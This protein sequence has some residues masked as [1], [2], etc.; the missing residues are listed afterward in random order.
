MKILFALFLHLSLNIVAQENIELKTMYTE[1]QNDRRSGAIDWDL[2]TKRDSTREKRVFEMLDSNLVKTSMDYYHAAMIFQHGG[3][4]IASSMAV[5]MMRHAIELDQTI[6]KW[7]LAA[8]IDRDLMRRGKP[9]IYG[10]QYRKMNNEPW[11][12]YDIDTTVISDTERR[13]YNVETLAEQ[14]AK[15]IS[16]NKTSLY[17]LY[18]SGITLDSIVMIITRESDLSN[19]EYN[20]SENGIN[21]FGYDLISMNLV[22]DALVIFRVNSEL[23]PKSSNTYDSLGECLLLLGKREEGIKAY[24]KALEL[25][26]DNTHAKGIVDKAE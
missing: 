17:D 15:V 11:K 16:M 8:A 18:V 23:Y 2:V 9:Q 24:K 14:R 4:T 19:S 22:E 26:P 5:K 20:L 21:E 25:N 12:L 3:D 1:D 10:T 6:N 13:E 7:L